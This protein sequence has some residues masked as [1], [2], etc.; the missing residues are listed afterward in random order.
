M[1][2]SC[3]S[4][5]CRCRWTRPVPDAPDSRRAAKGTREAVPEIAPLQ[6]SACLQ[7]HLGRRYHGLNAERQGG[8]NEAVYP[9]R[10]LVFVPIAERLIEESRDQS[11]FVV[12]E[13]IKLGRGKVDSG[14]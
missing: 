1:S 5:T 4:P 6:T 9:H 10:A 2:A 13:Q 3:R 14:T 12:G 7:T 8:R 11:Q